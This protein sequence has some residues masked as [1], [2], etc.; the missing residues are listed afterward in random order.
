[1]K[2]SARTE[3]IMTIGLSEPLQAPT[4]SPTAGPP[5]DGAPAAPLP[6]YRLNVEQYHKMIEVGVFTSDDRVELLE[7]LLVSTTP[8]NQPHSIAAGSIGDALIRIIPA[9]WYVAR[10]EPLRARDD[11]E[12][13]PDVMVVRGSRNDYPV[14]PPRGTDLALF[15]EVADSSLARDKTEKKRI[16]AE[17]GIPNYWL[18]N[19]LERRIELYTDPTGPGN[20][21]DYRRRAD[22]APG[23]DLPITIEGHVVGS[24]AVTDVLPK[25]GT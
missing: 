19:L 9:G 8:K 3:S 11:S 18:V 22:H 25:E 23:T 14:S 21:P 6:I 7:G 17:A 20:W 15:V 10:E 4:A 16:Y 5:R 24:L 12:P 1:M 13:E 2:P